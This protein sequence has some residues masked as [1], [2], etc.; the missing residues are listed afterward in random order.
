VKVLIASGLAE[1]EA[2][3]LLA[4]IGV[5]GFLSKPFTVSTL[6]EKVKAVLAGSQSPAP[7]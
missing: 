3:T 6:N 5:S 1:D 4:G 2:Y 7:R